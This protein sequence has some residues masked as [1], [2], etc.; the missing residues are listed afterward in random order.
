[1]FSS[2]LP[3][4]FETNALTRLAASLREAGVPLIDLTLSNPTRAGLPYP[5]GV[6]SSLAD[7][8]AVHYAPDPLGLPDTRAA[9]AAEYARLGANVAPDRVVL[10][11]S[12]S[13][14]YAHLFKLLCDPGDEVLVPRPSYPLFDWLT[15]LDAVTARPYWC[16]FHGRWSLDRDSVAAAISARTRAV[17]VVSPNNPTGAMLRDDDFAWLAEIA[18]ARDVAVI[19]DEVFLDYPLSPASAASLRS[20]AQASGALTFCL[21]GASKSLGLPQVKLGWIAASGP[22]PIVEAALERLG[23]IADTYL[24]VST[25]VQWAAPALFAAGAPIRAAIQN[26]LT[27]NLTALRTAIRGAPAVSLLEPEAG[28]SA[29]LRVPATV[30]EEAL[31]LRLLERDHVLVH[32]GYF[33]DFA[34]EAYL[35]VSLLPSSEV[36]DEGVRRVLR[37]VHES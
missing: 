16:E 17:L 22:A 12:T 10:T 35:V 2:R 7:P 26:R 27:R 31:V 1:M 6:L 30:S 15:R 36:F 28:W 5:D 25:P 13:D 3:P 20:R 34:D 18:A 9:V 37:A 23:I 33:F 24:S 14:A 29:V 8:R 21:G 11:S 4:E 32:P 19:V